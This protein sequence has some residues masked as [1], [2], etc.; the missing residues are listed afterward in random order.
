MAKN[1]IR[2]VRAGFLFASCICTFVSFL[3]VYA[4]YGVA[5]AWVEQ[6]NFC[7]RTS[8]LLYI[9]FIFLGAVFCTIAGYL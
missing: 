9:P 4:R 5:V 3:F 1:A 6:G 8:Y 7:V 2:Y